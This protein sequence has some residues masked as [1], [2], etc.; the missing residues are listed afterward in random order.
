MAN[1]AVTL[2]KT[3][4]TPLTLPERANGYTHKFSVLYSDL[5]VAAATGS[6]DT[7]TVTLGSGT[8][9]RFMVTQACA[10]IATLFTGTGALTVTAGSSG[11]ATIFLPSTTV[12]SGSLIQA[13]TGPNTVATPGSCFGTSAIIPTAVFTNATSGSPSALT[14]GQLDIYLAIL[15]LTQLG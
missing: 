5:A 13:T 8:P 9:A 15:D 14:A 10:V 4:F 11:S 12:L 3:R 1:F 2:P 6:T 7:I